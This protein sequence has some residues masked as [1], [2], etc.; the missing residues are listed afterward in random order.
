MTMLLVP[1]LSKPSQ[2]DDNFALKKSSTNPSLGNLMH[3]F[4]TSYSDF[5]TIKHSQA[6]DDL[7]LRKLSPSIHHR[8]SSIQILLSKQKQRSYK[9]QIKN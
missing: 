9:L 8:A 7:S 6:I 1:T 2:I 4:S 5:A 3:L